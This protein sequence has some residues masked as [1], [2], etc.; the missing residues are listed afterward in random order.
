MT[1]VQT[2]ALPIFASSVAGLGGSVGPAGYRTSKG[3][4]RLFAKAIAMECAAAGDNIRVNTV[5]P[6]VSPAVTRSLRVRAAAKSPRVGTP[7]GRSPVPA[8]HRFERTSAFGHRNSTEGTVSGS[9]TV[10]S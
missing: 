3:G 4:V 10:A 8:F 2:C 5:H 7:L 6:G 1:G 9:T